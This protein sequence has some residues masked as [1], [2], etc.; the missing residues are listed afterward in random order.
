VLD[1]LLWLELV[2][3]ALVCGCLQG[4]HEQ[5]IFFIGGGGV[6]C[7]GFCRSSIPKPV[8]GFNSQK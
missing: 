2:W 1:F 8:S 6:G 5:P 7:C 3:S 4:H